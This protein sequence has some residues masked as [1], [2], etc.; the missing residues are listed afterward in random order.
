VVRADRALVA[1]VAAIARE[2]PLVL[3][4][5][6][7]LPGEAVRKVIAAV[8]SARLGWPLVVSADLG[9]TKRHG[10][11]FPH[12]AATLGLPPEVIPHIGDSL[13]SDVAPAAEAGLWTLRWPRSPEWRLARRAADRI[14]RAQSRRAGMIPRG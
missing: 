11:L 2:K 5:C 1:L 10:A 12:V 9:L 14:A 6:A 7:D 4:S 3:I 8:A 13:V